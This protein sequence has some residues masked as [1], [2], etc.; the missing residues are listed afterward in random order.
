MQQQIWRRRRRRLQRERKISWSDCHSIS[1]KTQKL[2]KKKKQSWQPKENSLL[3]K[4][5]YHSKIDDQQ[6]LR[7][8]GP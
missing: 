5:Y 3:C 2:E 6:Y 4:L 8:P 7:S 1:S